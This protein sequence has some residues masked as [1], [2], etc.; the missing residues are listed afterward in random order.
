[1]AT[2]SRKMPID[3]VNFF[4]ETEV[5]EMLV[6][7]AVMFGASG[8]LAELL[9]EQQDL[10]AQLQEI[11]KQRETAR[12]SGASENDLIAA[13]NAI[14]DKRAAVESGWSASFRSMP[15]TPTPSRWTWPQPRLS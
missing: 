15:H 10:A 2:R 4:T 6:K 7:T 5:S 8:P 9:C 14:W 1:M 11:N 3:S 13:G 12:A